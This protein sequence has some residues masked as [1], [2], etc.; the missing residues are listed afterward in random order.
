MDAEHNMLTLETSNLHDLLQ[1]VTVMLVTAMPSEERGYL[2]TI[3]HEEFSLFIDHDLVASANP[4]VGLGVKVYICFFRA[5]MSD[6]ES[7]IGQ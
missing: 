6:S 4:S 5:E 2:D 3:K 1:Y 7:Q